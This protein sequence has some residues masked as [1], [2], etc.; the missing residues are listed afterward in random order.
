MTTKKNLMKA[1]GGM[2]LLPVVSCSPAEEQQPNVLLI[3]ADD[4]GKEW[5][6]QYGAED[7]E[8]P[9]LQRLADQSVV[10]DRAYSMAQSTPSRAC[11]LTGQYPYN[12]GWVNHFGVSNWENGFHFDADLNPC[13]TKQIKAAGYRTCIAGKW[14]LNDFRVEPEIMTELGFDEYL[15]WTGSQNGQEKPVSAA[16]RY[17]DPYLHSKEGSRSY[18][19]KFGPD[20]YSVFIIDFIGTDQEEPFFVYYPMALVHMPYVNTPHSMDAKTQKEKHVGMIKYMDYTIGK[21]IDYLEREGL[22]DD[23]YVIFTTDNGTAKTCFN[24]RD[25]QIV[26]GGK[27]VLSENGVNCPF[28]VHVPG[29]RSSRT[30]SAIVDFTDLAPTILDITGSEREAGHQLDGQSF[31][32]VLQG[33][34]QPE[35]ERYAVCL[36]SYPAKINAEGRVVNS[37]KFRDRVIIGEHY[38]VYVTADRKID[39][40]YRIGQDPFEQQNLVD[41]HLEA[42]LEEVGAVLEAMPAKDRNFN[43]RY[44]EHDRRFDISAAELNALSDGRDYNNYRPLGTEE[45]YNN[46]QNGIKNKEK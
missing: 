21:I 9:N 15:M 42:A 36:G 8:L 3:L 44:L 23:T 14:Q 25:G 29:Q 13:F 38:K 34:E 7:I 20:L 31:L 16:R 17:W 41:T 24:K 18:P 39:R 35:E 46:F 5:I 27:S 19:G 45:E 32:P 22:M 37:H 26:I 12:S 2:M 10:F 33:K 11:I 1:A 30:T 4:L 40:I 43:Y 28:M 6:Q